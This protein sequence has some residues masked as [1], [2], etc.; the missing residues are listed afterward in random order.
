MNRYM[1]LLI[2]EFFVCFDQGLIIAILA[3]IENEEEVFLRFILFKIRNLFK[4]CCSTYN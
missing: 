3:F 2:Q 4:E 1:K